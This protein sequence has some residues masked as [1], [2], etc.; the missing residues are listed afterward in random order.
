MIPWTLRFRP[1]FLSCGSPRVS[2]SQRPHPRSSC[3]NSSALLPLT[4]PLLPLL[5]TLTSQLSGVP[6]S[7]TTTAS[8]SSGLCVQFPLR[9]LP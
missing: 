9:T 6:I 4:P 2:G 3:P 5:P 8:G 7:R 1:G